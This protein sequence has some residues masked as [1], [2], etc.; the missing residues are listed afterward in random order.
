MVLLTGRGK[1]MLFTLPTLIEGA[2]TSIVVVPFTALM[3]DLMDRVQKSGWI[4][5]DGS[6][7]H[8]KEV[9]SVGS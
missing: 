9:R 3:D 6:R 2:G 8:E 1:S 7:N 4:V 5:F